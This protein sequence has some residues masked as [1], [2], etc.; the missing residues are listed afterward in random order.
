MNPPRVNLFQRAVQN[1]TQG[2]TGN[3]FQKLFGS[4][5]ATKSSTS[6]FGQTA[7]QGASQGAPPCCSHESVP[8]DKWSLG[9]L[10]E[11]KQAFIKPRLLELFNLKNNLKQKHHQFRI[12]RACMH[13]KKIQNNLVKDLNNMAYIFQLVLFRNPYEIIATR[14]Q[15]SDKR[16]LYTVY[17]KVIKALLL[18]KCET[19]ADFLRY[20]ERQII[21]TGDKR[22]LA[23]FR[24]LDANNIVKLSH[25]VYD[26]VV[27]FLTAVILLLNFEGH[28]QL[29]LQA[30]LTCCY[31]PDK[32]S[33]IL[34]DLVAACYGPTEQTSTLHNDLEI[35]A[36]IKEL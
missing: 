20:L 7:P 15:D 24:L 12:A 21:M 11:A 25:D 36:W 34:T 19:K 14:V 17:L 23:T 33:R 4:I 5:A 9:H 28:P 18:D 27:G 10:S 13:E 22:L 26:E 32:V 2:D 35:E 16:S 31:Y 1:A 30:G 8:L 3:A 6:A 29:T